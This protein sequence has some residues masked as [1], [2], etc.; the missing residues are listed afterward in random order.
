MKHKNP[1]PGSHFCGPST[2]ESQ[3]TRR[4]G[5]PYPF[6]FPRNVI[7][8]DERIFGRLADFSRQLSGRISGTAVCA[9]VRAD[10]CFLGFRQVQ[11]VHQARTQSGEQTQMTFPAWLGFRIMSGKRHLSDGKRLT[12]DTDFMSNSNRVS[13]NRSSSA[14][15]LRRNPR[16][17]LASSM[18]TARPCPV[19]SAPRCSSATP[20]ARTGAAT[21][22]WPLEAKPLRARPG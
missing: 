10:R 12:S 19:R 18:P 14:V 21:A 22:A 16:L 5:H 15:E 3:M 8:L 20:A 13:G 9:S 7:A 6:D 4:V 11:S 1:T 17:A 2:H